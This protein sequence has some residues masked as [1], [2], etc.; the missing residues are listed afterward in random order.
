M[1]ASAAKGELSVFVTADAQGKQVDAG[2]IDSLNHVLN[3]GVESAVAGC[4]SSSLQ[5]HNELRLY[6]A[7]RFVAFIRYTMLQV[8]TLIAFVAYGY[9]VA[10]LSIM[11][12]AFEGRKTLGD[13][14]LLT[15]VVLL[16]WIGTMMVQFQRNGMLSR[17]EGSTPGEASYFQVALHLLTVGGLPLL[18]IVTTQ[19]PAVGNFILL[20]FRP[21]L[22]TLH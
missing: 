7:L 1:L 3:V 15:F 5:F 19:F 22:G 2:E 8:G 6:L 12:Y 10:V 17:L 14:S 9:V 13:L 21:L 4:P 11:F 16:I 20:M 18:A